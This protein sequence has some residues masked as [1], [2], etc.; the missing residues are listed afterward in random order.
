MRNYRTFFLIFSILAVVALFLGVQFLLH[1]QPSVRADNDTSA[2]N[3]LSAGIHDTQNL[4]A[5]SGTQFSQT[6]G[7]ITVEISY[8]KIITTGVEIGLCY[9]TPDGG[10]WYPGPGP[11]QYGTQ[12][13]LPDEAGFTSETP[14]DGTNM[15]KR[16]GY[17][18]YRV[19]KISGSDTP[20]HFVLKDIHAI[21][22]EMPA[23]QNLQ[24]RVDTNP[25]AQS[26]GLKISCSEI[27]DQTVSAKVIG[28]NSSFTAAEAQSAL[29]TILQGAVIGPWEFSINNLQ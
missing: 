9:T 28:F 19:E 12:N 23:C 24:Q 20:V 6:V 26:L 22:R 18:R 7:D 4:Q 11:L 10:D 8:A 29:D 16:C 17:I 14:A 5:Q 13:I 15:G 27:E 2:P 1:P 21:P 25:K 3:Q